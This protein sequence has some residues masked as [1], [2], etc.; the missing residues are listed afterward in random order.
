[1]DNTVP[2]DSRTPGRTTWAIERIKPDA[3]LDSNTDKMSP[4]D[5]QKGFFGDMSNQ[6][7]SIDQQEINKELDKAVEGWKKERRSMIA[8]RK[9]AMEKE[10]KDNYLRIEPESGKK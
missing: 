7:T 1:M 8:N 9:K 2:K 4:E 3:H 6:V 5:V 10:K